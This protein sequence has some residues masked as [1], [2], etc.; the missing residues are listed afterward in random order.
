MTYAE[1]AQIDG[2][3]AHGIATSK[4]VGYMARMAGKYSLLGFLKKDVYNCVD[5]TRRAKIS[6]G[7]ANAA[8]VYLEGKDGSDL[9][10]VAR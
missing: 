9:T 2:L 6:D 7:D 3:H 10:S 5:K 4:I 1:K 8:I